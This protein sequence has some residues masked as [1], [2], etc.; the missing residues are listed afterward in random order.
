MSINEFDENYCKISI[1]GF[2]KKKKNN[3]AGTLF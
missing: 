3:Y 1:A 2:L